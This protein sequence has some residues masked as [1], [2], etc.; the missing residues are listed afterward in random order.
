MS[1]CQLK[2]GILVSLSGQ[3]QVQGRQALAGLQAWA[4]DVNGSGGV[5]V[6]EPGERLTVTVRYY[7]DGSRSDL[8]RRATQRLISEDQVDLLFGPYSSV[9]TR[10]AAEV[11]NQNDRLLWNQG[12][13]S[14]AIHQQGNPW[15]VGI[16]SPASEYLA[17][18]PLLVRQSDP[19]ASRLAIIRAATGAFPQAV[20][21]GMERKAL[22]LGFESVIKRVFDPAITDFAEILDTVEQARPDLLLG[23]GRIQNDLLLARQIAQRRCSFGAVAVAVVAAP[24]QQF[25]THLMAAAEG[26]LGPSQ[27]ELTTKQPVEY[28]PT[29]EQVLES[30]AVSGGASGTEVDYPLVQAY[31]AGLVAQRCVEEAGSLEPGALREAAVNL[32]FSTFYGRFRIDPAT[33]VQTGRSPLI[34]QW[35]QGRK[36]VVWPRS[37]SQGSLIYPWPGSVGPGSVGPG[38]GSAGPGSAGPGSA[39]PGSAGPG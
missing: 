17:G 11:A 7:D 35:Q 33:G 13:A 29:A 34:V 12:G 8:A 16:L 2:V 25:K 9:L 3:F 19:K 28:G 32:D 24:I 22:D 30:I 5:W 39:G 18:L 26:F 21:D 38:P 20:S 27:W 6:R 1:S 36:V 15:V 4:R 37:L 14:D 23:V 31:A 10:A